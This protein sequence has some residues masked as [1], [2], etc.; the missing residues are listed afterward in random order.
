MQSFVQLLLVVLTV[1]STVRAQ[2]YAAPTLEPMGSCLSQS[3]ACLEAVANNLGTW[4][5]CD[6]CVCNNFDAVVNG[7]DALDYPS[8]FYTCQIL[9]NGPKQE[10]L[11]TIGRCVPKVGV[12]AACL[13]GFAIIITGLAL[14]LKCL[15]S[16]RRPNVAFGTEV[17]IDQT[18]SNRNQHNV[19]ATYKPPVT[20]SVV[21]IV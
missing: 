18:S 10:N 12:F 21:N 9:Q 8:Q 13:F 1:N 17:L 6:M 5:T 3:V 16:S 14:L 20:M 7:A 15:C 11:D 2:L 19:P 4:Q